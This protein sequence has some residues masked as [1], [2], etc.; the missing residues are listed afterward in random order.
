MKISH[1]STIHP[2]KTKLFSDEIAVILGT[3]T[4]KENKVSSWLFHLATKKQ[5]IHK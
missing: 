2:L 5:I 3:P 4:G 1:A